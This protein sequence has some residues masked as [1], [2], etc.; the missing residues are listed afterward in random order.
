[1]REDGRLEKAQITISW[2][3]RLINLGCAR[4]LIGFLSSDGSGLNA[5][6]QQ[7][8]PESERARGD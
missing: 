1:M 3:C 7:S 5:R 2:G 6:L 8:L 4:A